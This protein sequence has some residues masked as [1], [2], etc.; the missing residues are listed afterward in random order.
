M[1]PCIVLWTVEFFTPRQSKGVSSDTLLPKNNPHIEE[2]P[3][4]CN[5]VKLK[6]S[7]TIIEKYN[8]KTR[9]CIFSFETVV[10][11]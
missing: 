9:S 5:C 2:Y 6:A 10:V 3:C 11:V 8:G 4:D 1:F 7:F